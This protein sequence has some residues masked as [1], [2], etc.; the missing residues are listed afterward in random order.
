VRCHSVL[1]RQVAMNRS[2]FQIAKTVLVL[3]QSIARR[4]GLSP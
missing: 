4:M 1:V 3:P 2:P